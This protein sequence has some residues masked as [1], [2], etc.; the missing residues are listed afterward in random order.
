MI[1]IDK[2]TAPKKLQ[3]NGG[4]RAR[5]HCAEYD[6]DPREYNSG[7]KTFKFSTAIYGH[8]TVK[9]A[10][11]KAQHGKC[12]YC[13]VIIP[14]PYALS[15]VDHYRPKAY[16]RQGRN[17]KKIFPGYYWLAYRWSNLF[18]ACHF[19]NSSNKRNF[20]PLIDE[21]SRAKNHHGNINAER[22]LII[23]PDG[24]DDPRDHIG[25]HREIPFGK[26]SVGRA[27]VEFLGLDRSE[28]ELRL[29]LFNQ[30]RYCYGLV[31]K[32]HADASLAAKEVVADAQAQL[33]SA[34]RAGAPFSAMA[35][36]FLERHPLP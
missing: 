13:E 16:S 29:R 35:T 6:G 30:L 22:P 7:R 4:K 14:K 19:C 8:S 32:Y 1:R 28:H 10:L 3:S 21:A 25:F 34:V 12:C 33:T 18:L 27:T 20:F 11:D 5:K 36:A 9:A 31:V 15:H 26:T 2:G 23:R 24:P 17:E